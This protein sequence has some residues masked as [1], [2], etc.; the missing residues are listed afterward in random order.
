MSETLLDALA[1]A[2]RNRGLKLMR[3]RVRTP[4][5]D[6]FGKVGLLD[7]S[8]KPKF[9]ID[10]TGPA[11]SADE[12]EAYLKEL[13]AGDWG[14]SL[15]TGEQPNRRSRETKSAKPAAVPRTMAPRQRATDQNPKV[16]AARSSDAPRLVELIAELGAAIDEKS[17][18][19]NLAFL[20]R[21]DEMPLV[22][23][24]GGDVVGLCGIGRRIAVHRPAPLGRITALVVKKEF[25]G[26]GIGRLLVEAAEH[27]MQQ[28]GCYIVE[29]TSNDKRTD[30]HAF[31]RRLGYERTSI[32]FAKEL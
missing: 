7:A 4:G 3:S 2:A 10:D 28:G 32:R 15:K 25:R 1:A 27:W 17:V 23:T 18:R 19:S 16:R 20:K 26:K 6:R 5:K 22:A 14:A 31:Y 29:V 12:V 21:R 24:I 9:G 13:E 30:A 8:G 11:A